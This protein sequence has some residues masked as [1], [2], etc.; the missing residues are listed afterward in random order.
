MNE[1][2]PIVSGDFVMPVSSIG[3]VQPFAGSRAVSDP[4][5]SAPGLWQILVQDYPDARPRPILLTS[6]QKAH[7]PDEIFAKL[8]PKPTDD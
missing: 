6:V 3:E 4:W 7:V 8:F 2:H 5:E 1:P